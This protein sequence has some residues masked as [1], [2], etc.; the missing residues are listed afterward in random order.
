MGF[1]PGERLRDVIGEHPG[2]GDVADRPAPQLVL[3][4]LEDPD[5][6]PLREQRHHQCAGEAELGQQPPLG[7]IDLLDISYDPMV[8]VFR[9]SGS[10]IDGEEG[11]NMQGKSLDEYPL[12]HHRE[13]VRRTYMRVLENG[14]PDYEEIERLNEG[15]VARYGR[16]ILPL[17]ERGDRIDQFLMA[18]YALQGRQA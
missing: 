17:S 11:F 14:E 7:N 2:H 12:P 18:R 5:W 4:E 8:F 6:A 16:L 13:D 15:K 1:E 3:P 9:V 10:N